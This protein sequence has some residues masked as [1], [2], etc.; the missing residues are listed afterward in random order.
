MKYIKNISIF[1]LWLFLTTGCNDD[2]LDLAPK[3]ELSGATQFATYNN[4]KLYAWGFYDF[5]QA[6]GGKSSGNMIWNDADSDMLQVGSGNVGR[7]YTWQ[8]Y[9]VPSESEIY[10]DGFA[11]IRK[12]NLMLDNIDNSDMTSEDIAH[13]RGVGLFF[14]AQEYFKLLSYYGGVTW[15][16][17]TLTDTDT[18]ILFGPRDTRDLVADNILR[19]LLEAVETVK[20]TGDGPN[21][22][23][24]NVVRALLSRFGLFE[25]TW[26]KYHA[27]DS[28][29]KFLNASLAASQVLVNNF[30]TLHSNYDQVFNSDDLGSR[31]GILLY[32]HYVIDIL[33]HNMNTNNRSTNNKFDITRKGIDKF[34]YK[35]GKTIWDTSSAYYDANSDKDYYSEFRNRDTRMLIITPPPYQVN[36][37]GSVDQWT[38]ITD[39]NGQHAEYFAVLE[40]LTGGFP[41]KTLP[42]LNWAGR[43]T[44]GV[45]NF[46]QLAPTQ[47]GSGYRL[48]KIYNEHNE[49]VSSADIN[50]APIFRMGEVMLN[51]AEVTFELGQFDQAVADATISKLR[52]R[53]GVAPLNITAL[54]VD[55]TRD[56]SVDPV[57]WEIR[58]ERAIELM[59]DG[60]RR[61]DLRRWK[62]MDYA[63]DVKLGRWIK[64][65]DYSKNINIQ[66]NAAEGYVQLISGQAPVFSEHYYLFPLPSKELVLN[67]NLEQNPNW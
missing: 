27:M 30:P 4:V 10:S 66:N 39:E 44:G 2:F 46:Q 47:T 8:T 52:A 26:R 29:E 67:P 53:G 63:T 3:D 23:N 19:D 16:E 1:I 5:F 59:A 31:N 56:P 43:A 65:T 28:P 58:R 37:N 49:R 25:G 32:K 42:D 48:W 22:I 45:P 12:I 54:S 38:H 24:A 34:L 36:G 64:Q 40:N 15:L 51:H 17:H 18:D 21:T 50:D 33:T 35:D 62:K 9:N 41:Y 7:D 6:Y 60:F 13:W 61:E 55:P 57:L 20:E 11:N 14:R